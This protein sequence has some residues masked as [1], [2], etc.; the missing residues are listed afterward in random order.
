[1]TTSGAL[2]LIPRPTRPK[3]RRVAP[4]IGTYSV[5]CADPPWRYDVSISKSRE[6]E[7][8]YPTT[9]Q[10]RRLSLPLVRC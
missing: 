5:L 7:N 2:G 10:V 4:P 3:P 8:H 6:V 1:M 9:T